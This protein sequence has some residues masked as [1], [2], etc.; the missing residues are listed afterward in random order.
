MEVQKV[1]KKY[2]RHEV[3]QMHRDGMSFSDIGQV[4]GVSRQRAY[5]LYK[6]EVNR[7]MSNTTNNPTIH[8]GS[9]NGGSKQ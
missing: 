9:N 8:N 4:F 5:Q 1:A 3:V 7:S 2:N 6:R